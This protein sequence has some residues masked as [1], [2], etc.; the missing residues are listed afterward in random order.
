MHAPASHRHAA[1]HVQ[2]KLH[3]V[4]PP[5]A[6]MGHHPML[7]TD[8]P[9]SSHCVNSRQGVPTKS[10]KKQKAKGTADMRHTPLSSNSSSCRGFGLVVGKA[11]GCAKGSTWGCTTIPCSGRRRYCWGFQ[12]LCKLLLR[13][14]SC[15]CVCVSGVHDG[16]SDLRL[17]CTGFWYSAAAR[18]RPKIRPEHDASPT[19]RAPPCLSPLLQTGAYWRR[20]CSVLLDISK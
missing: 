10:A 1:R 5:K 2:Y 3:P 8:D 20:T 9:P 17:F 15:V 14:P 4:S 7:S 6:L 13:F 18:G 12:F 16:A 19:M 11:D